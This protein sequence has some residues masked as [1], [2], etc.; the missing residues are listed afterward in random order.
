[1]T[2]AEAKRELQ[3]DLRKSMVRD[4]SQILATTKKEDLF[5]QTVLGEDNIILG[6]DVRDSIMFEENSPYVQNADSSRML[7]NSNSV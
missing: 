6:Q 3:E 4:T 1:M 7:I 5:G 2:L